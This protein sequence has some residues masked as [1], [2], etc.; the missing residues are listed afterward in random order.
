MML[1]LG[2]VIRAFFFRLERYAR[3]FGIRA[4]YRVVLERI[5]NRPKQTKI[6]VLFL[7]SEI[8][9]WKAQT[10]YDLLNASSYYEPIIGLTHFDFDWDLPIEEQ[11]AKYETARAFFI[12]RDMRIVDM[13]DHSKK[14]AVSPAEVGADVVF[15]QMPYAI[16]PKQS[17]RVVGINAL[18]C[19]IP[20]YVVNNTNR[21][22][23]YGNELHRTV[24]R[25]FIL[26]D[27]IAKSYRD[28]RSFFHFSG[29]LLGLGHP[30][31]DYYRL[32]E[33]DKANRDYV[34]YAPHWSFSHPNNE[35]CENFSTFL[36]TAEFMLE[37]ARIHKGMNWVFR[38]HP[39][40]R[41]ALLRSGAWGAEK[42]NDYW[43]AWMDVGTLST[44]GEYQELLLK[45]RALITDCGSFL[46]E[47]FVIGKPL[48]HLISK[49]AKMFPCKALQKYFDTFYN[50]YS[51]DELRDTLAMVLERSEDPMKAH[52]N[53]VRVKSKLAD[54]YAAQ[55][56][57]RYFDKVFH[58]ER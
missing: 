49:D 36:H 18:T 22:F 43:K 12:S 58:V 29:K 34:I 55:N 48:I 32:H 41:H 11:R 30:S 16:H 50:V 53:E 25:Y 39:T 27:D 14:E 28:W 5:R 15:Y 20:Y 54:N 1:F 47:Y 8:A 45:S 52:R 10:L 6:K 24:W 7:T 37:Y 2:K 57:I 40:L 31:L 56:I 51:L 4:G 19:Y 21:S 9:K 33:S 3:V 46:T 38:P 42:V 17:P 26:N 35:N 44:G 13:Y 23:D